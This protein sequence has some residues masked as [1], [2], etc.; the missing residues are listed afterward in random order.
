MCVV[1]NR[2]VVDRRLERMNA[3]LPAPRSY[4]VVHA[5][6]DDA[7]SIDEPLGAG[8]WSDDG[9]FAVGGPPEVSPIQQEADK[10][11]A[12]ARAEARFRAPE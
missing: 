12:N 10:R 8:T 9:S 7:R 2:F 11:P 4:P 1:E 6:T 3:A 5:D